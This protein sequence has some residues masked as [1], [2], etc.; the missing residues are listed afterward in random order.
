MTREARMEK[1]RIAGRLA[2]ARGE[3][4]DSRP[5]K[6]RVMQNAWETAWNKARKEKDFKETLMNK[7]YP[8]RKA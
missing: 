4:F 3:S 6:S 5:Y 1:A 2:Y 7:L 8:G